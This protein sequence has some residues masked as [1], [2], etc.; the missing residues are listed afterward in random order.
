VSSAL[1]CAAADRSIM[2]MSE[3]QQRVTIQ[4]P[5]A[6]VQFIAARAEQEERSVASVVRRLISEAERREPRG[7]AA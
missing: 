5:A 1:K 7:R 4:L 2:R 6:L 3:N